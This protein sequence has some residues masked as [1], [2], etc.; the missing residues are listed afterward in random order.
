MSST[1][2]TIKSGISDT[3]VTVQ[4]STII[5]DKKVFGVF[6]GT[7]SVTHNNVTST[8]YYVNSIGEGCIL[9]SNYGGE[10]QN[11]DYITTCPI[12]DGGYGS[13]QTD[14]IMHSYTVAKCTEDIVWSSITET[15]SYNGNTYKIYLTSCTYHCG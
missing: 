11:G 10:I 14:D 5:N 15:I 2:N 12:G 7:E 9:I 4:P 13:L 6:S 3:L 8:V 1:G